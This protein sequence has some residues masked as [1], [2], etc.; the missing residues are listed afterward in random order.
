[1]NNKYSPER[2]LERKEMTKKITKLIAEHDKQKSFAANFE[3]FLDSC[4][5]IFNEQP[6]QEQAEKFKAAW[7]ANDNFSQAIELVGEGSEDYTDMLGEI[8]MDNVSHG[9]K[10]QF[11][12]P[13]NICE[14]MAEITQ[15]DSDKEMETVSD[16]CCGS[17]RMLL[18]R[19]KICREQ[20][21]QCRIIA[22][23]LDMTACKMTL[24][25]LL[26][27]TA[28]GVVTCGDALRNETQ[29]AF[30]VRRQ[31]AP[32]RLPKTYISTFKEINTNN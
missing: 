25:N 18:A 1:M 28:E 27:Q 4:L 5:F 12:T 32:Y 13:Q 16:C 31:V 8:F 23:D 21:R 20:G 30:F 19:L 26:L 14:L 10:G 6:T 11:F 17:G 29:R 15:Q 22:N 3:S 7:Y 9:A 2:T 24:L